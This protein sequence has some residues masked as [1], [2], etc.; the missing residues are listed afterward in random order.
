ML[1]MP[2]AS[3]TQVAA[4]ENLPALL[5]EPET[6]TL[7]VAPL[8]EAMDTVAMPFMAPCALT[9]ARAVRPLTCVRTGCGMTVTLAVRL[10]S[11]VVVSPATGAALAVMLRLPAG[12]PVVLKLT[13]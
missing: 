8:A 9:V 6:C 5:N 11:A 3:V 7:G 12:A 10:L 4:T 1:H 13:V 2:L